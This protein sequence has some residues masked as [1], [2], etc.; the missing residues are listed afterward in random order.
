[1]PGSAPCNSQGY[2]SSRRKGALEL[3]HVA[4]AH[5]LCVELGG[6]ASVAPHPAEGVTK[7][8]VL[9]TGLCWPLGRVPTTLTSY[10]N[11][12]AR[13]AARQAEEPR[14]HVHQSTAS[15]PA[16][17][18]LPAWNV[19]NMLSCAV[20]A[21]SGCP[22]GNAGRLGGAFNGVRNSALAKGEHCRLMQCT[23][24]LGRNRSC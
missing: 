14:K 4:S 22:A 17:S 3:L 15:L 21:G 13:C 20:K 2:L 24:G 1:M 6:A 19:S 18:L 9:D 11:T 23:M 7:L 16:A 12:P 8:R 10:C 5:C